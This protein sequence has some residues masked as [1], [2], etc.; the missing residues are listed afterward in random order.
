MVH[1]QALKHSNAEYLARDPAREVTDVTLVAN[2]QW[3]GSLAS[4][5]GLE[6]R[7]DALDLDLVYQGRTPQGNLRPPSKR[8]TVGWDIILGAP[9]SISLLF[10]DGDHHQ[11]RSVI[12]AHERGVDA[13]ITYLEESVVV[14]QRRSLH[15]E[16]LLVRGICVARFTHGVSR[17]LDPH[18]HSHVSL[19]NF[20]QAQDGRFGAIDARGLFAHRHA[21][22][23]LY[24]AVMRAHLSTTLDIPFASL[25]VGCDRIVGITRTQELAFSN[26]RIELLEGRRDRDAKRSPS[27]RD[28]EV[29]WQQRA[30][31]VLESGEPSLRRGSRVID[32][33]RFAQH[34]EASSFRPR[35]VVAS[36]CNAASQ[37]MG[38]E[39][40]RA[41]SASWDRRRGIGVHEPSLM[42]Q[43]V[44]VSP[45]VLR[46]LGPRPSDLEAFEKWAVARDVL[47]LERHRDVRLPSHARGERGLR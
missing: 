24:R 8:S 43:E 12:E 36:L 42:R 3:R 44:M 4:V 46:V 35:D 31:R 38:V 21:I 5:F 6:G 11:A 17:S 32:E 47:D 18:L 34:L 1:L 39:T 33:Y 26:R 16:P 9:K 19:A 20:A 30:E 14:A 15:G 7:V 29:W 2:S 23:G 40:L 27:R 45:Q 25:D 41:M 37:G 10:A 22:D 13:A 28:L